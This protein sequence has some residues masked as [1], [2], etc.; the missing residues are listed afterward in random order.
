LHA[1]FAQTPRPAVSARWA[2][3][4]RQGLQKRLHIFAGNVDYRIAFGGVSRM[5]E[6]RDD[7][8]LPDH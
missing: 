8:R 7:C 2:R 4:N 1:A 3:Q 5:P 6:D